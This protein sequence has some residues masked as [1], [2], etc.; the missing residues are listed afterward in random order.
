[1][2]LTSLSIRRPLLILMAVL[3]I[4]L[5]G[6][7]AY[8]SMAVDLLPNVKIPYVGIVVA[9]PGAGP[10][11]VESRVTK[12]IENAVAGAPGVKSL[13][14]TSSEGFSLVLLEFQDGVDQDKAAQDAE[15]RVNQIASSLPD[16]AL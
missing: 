14:S 15:R 1:M 11:E 2:W 10:S 12:P 16:G 13:T 5:G 6:T 8:R 7:L 3:A 4:M 9:Y